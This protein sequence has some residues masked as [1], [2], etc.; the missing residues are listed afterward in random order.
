MVDVHESKRVSLVLDRDESRAAAIRFGM[1]T[2]APRYIV[3]ENTRLPRLDVISVGGTRVSFDFESGAPS[4]YEIPKNFW[5][6]IKTHI[7][8]L[9]S[10]LPKTIK[11]SYHAISVGDKFTIDVEISDNIRGLDPENYLEELVVVDSVEGDTVKCLRGLLRFSKSEFER[12]QE[13]GEIYSLFGGSGLKL[14]FSGQ[15]HILYISIRPYDDDFDTHPPTDNGVE[16]FNVITDSSYGR[17]VNSAEEEGWF[18]V[19]YTLGVNAL[20]RNLDAIR[21]TL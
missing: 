15:D 21:C 20:T 11:D 12:A 1:A 18:A 16:L 3:A 4:G 10:V 9:W 7:P 6:L 17:G 5:W 8:T 19:L 14:R 2:Y 13:L